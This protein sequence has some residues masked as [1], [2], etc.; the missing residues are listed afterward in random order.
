MVDTLFPGWYVKDISL[1]A[2]VENWKE[3]ERAM[4]YRC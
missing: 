3:L 1:E 4:R 2:G